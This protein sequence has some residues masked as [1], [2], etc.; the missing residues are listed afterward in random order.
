MSHWGGPE[1]VD[2]EE[3]DYLAK[4]MY[5]C[6][7]IKYTGLHRDVNQ[8]SPALVEGGGSAIDAKR[9]H[10]EHRRAGD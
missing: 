4:N 5:V 8:C 3:K 7:N 10:I 2:E 9:L 1:P 6:P